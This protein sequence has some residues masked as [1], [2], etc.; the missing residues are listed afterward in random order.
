MLTFLSLKNKHSIEKII[1]LL[2]ISLIFT[3]I[4]LFFTLAENITIFIHNK[5][6]KDSYIYQGG[7]I[8]VELEP[9]VKMTKLKMYK[10]GNYYVLSN[11]N[12]IPPSSY[13]SLVY[14][15]NKP[16]KYVLVKE[17]KVYIDLFEISY[18]TGAVVEFNKETGIVDYYN[19]AKLEETAKQVYSSSNQIY[20]TQSEI[21]KQNKIIEVGDKQQ[22]PEDAIKI[23][24]ENQIYDDKNNRGELRYNAKVKNTY[25]EPIQDVKIKLKIVSPANDVLYQQVF[26]YTVLK[27]NESKE[28]SLYWINNTTVS[29]PQIKVEI[30]FK[31]KEDKE[32]K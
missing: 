2:L 28:I 14:F 20:N 13:S 22:I 32:K 7:R 8:F 18:F 1:N 4:I 5:P 23:V 3:F 31:G 9:F 21:Y 29:N 16:L 19:K 6:Y 27:P 26:S 10:Q 17:T 11:S 30:D 15:N 24:E 25:K 12:L